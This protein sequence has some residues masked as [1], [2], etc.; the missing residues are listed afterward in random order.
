[1][2][3]RLPKTEVELLQQEV[4]R[5]SREVEEL[6]GGSPPA[7]E[8]RASVWVRLFGRLIYQ[9]PK[10]C[11]QCRFWRLHYSGSRARQGDCRLLAGSYN[12]HCNDACEQFEP[13]RKYMRRVK[14]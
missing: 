14:R 2:T 7:P 3:D 11:D 12:T 6:K 13:R 4:T 1:M 8:K 9:G 10:T 5:L